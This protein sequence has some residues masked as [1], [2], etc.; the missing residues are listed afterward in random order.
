MDNE[1]EYIDALE[2]HSEHNNKPDPNANLQV[3]KKD[4]ITLS[5]EKTQNNAPHESDS[6]MEE[7]E[8]DKHEEVPLSLQQRIEK[9]EEQAVKTGNEINKDLTS[10]TLDQSSKST[11]DKQITQ[12]MLSD[13][14]KEVENTLKEYNARV[15]EATTSTQADEITEIQKLHYK[16]T[17][18]KEKLEE[19]K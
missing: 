14:K 4:E 19:E 1:I 7:E 11:I 16:L 3:E 8:D 12:I 15:E 10:G 18:L 13:V 17:K 6:N 5:E 9:A 2:F